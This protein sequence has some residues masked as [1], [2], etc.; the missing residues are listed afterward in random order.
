MDKINRGLSLH[1]VTR[2]ARSVPKECWQNALSTLLTFPELAGGVYVEGYTVLGGFGYFIEHGWIESGGQI[3]DTTPAF[4]YD[5]ANIYFPGVRLKLSD[6][7]RIVRL[8]LPRNRFEHSAT[9]RAAYYAAQDYIGG[10]KCQTY[11]K[12]GEFEGE[13]ESPWF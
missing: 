5:P 6:A 10:L 9:M 13:K 4:L 11:L 1:Y 8:P 7:R 3:I 2:G 12:M